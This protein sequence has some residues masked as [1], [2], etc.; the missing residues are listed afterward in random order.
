MFFEIKVNS[1]WARYGIITYC[2]VYENDPTKIQKMNIALD[3]MIYEVKAD[4]PWVIELQ[5]GY[6]SIVPLM[7]FKD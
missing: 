7:I 1:G 6:L 2:E 4:Y 5:M 3:Y